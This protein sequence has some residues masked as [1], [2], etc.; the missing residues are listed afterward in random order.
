MRIDVKHFLPLPI[1]FCSGLAVAFSLSLL[2]PKRY[3]AEAEL[4]MPRNGSS[5]SRVQRIEY[6]ALDPRAAEDFVTRRLVEEGGEVLSPPSVRAL[7]AQREW[8]LAFGGLAGLLA[9][10]ALV[11]ARL[12]RRR[13]VRGEAA[14]AAALGEPLFATRLF[15]PEALDGLCKQ[16]LAHWFTADHPILPVA[17]ALPGE[18]RS[19]LALELARRFAALGEK[20]LLIDADLRSPSLH[21]A[22]RL[23]NAGGL[24]NILAGQQSGLTNAGFQEAGPNLAVLTAGH[25]EGDPLELLRGERLHALLAAV[26]KHFRAIVIDVPAAARGPDFEIFAALGRGAL[27]VTRR[28]R[29]DVAG[30]ERL[31]G[32]LERCSARVVATVVD[33]R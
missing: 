15:Q 3:I 9:G 12:R 4:L 31:R 16:L 22:L 7:R 11:V 6:V 29:A 28:S 30:L 27:V 13:P 2:S 33:P 19:R 21:R 23:K 17:S 24:A 10:A 32:E 5:E 1:A 8:T 18:G 14:L 25:P 26:A 20:T